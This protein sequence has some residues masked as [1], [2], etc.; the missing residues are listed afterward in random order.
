MKLLKL[1]TMLVISYALSGCLYGQCMDGMCALERAKYLKS[2]KAYGEF[3]TKPGITKEEWRQDWRDCGGMKDGN[4][5]N[6]APS[7]SSDAVLTAANNKKVKE[8][9]TCMKEKG[10]EFSY[11]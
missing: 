11:K 10:Y 8:L 6:D 7:G 1:S 4:Y 3:W 9:S 5:S 2:I